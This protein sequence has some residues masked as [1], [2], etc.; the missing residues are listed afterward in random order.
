MRQT[1]CAI[2]LE[3]STRRRTLI[4]S[5][6]CRMYAVIVGEALWAYSRHIQATTLDIQFIEVQEGF[7]PADAH[8]PDSPRIIARWSAFGH[9]E[10]PSEPALCKVEQQPVS[11]TSTLCCPCAEPQ[12]NRET[13]SALSTFFPTA[14]EWAPWKTWRALDL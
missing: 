6:S 13:R 10:K 5:T 7:F 8:A 9:D 2:W 11:S 3:T 4:A 1:N 14:Q 12:D